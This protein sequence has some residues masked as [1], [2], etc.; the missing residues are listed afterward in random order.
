MKLYRRAEFLK[1]PSG[2]LYCTGPEFAFGCIEVKADSLGVDWVSLHLN[3]IEANDSGE[4]FAR[5]E[6]MLEAGASYPLNESF[7]RDGMF[8]D[9]VVFLVFEAPDLISLRSYIDDALAAAR[10]A[11]AP[12]TERTT[13]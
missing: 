10:P 12:E 1:L 11:D 2:T 7:G 8:D 4:C 9:D 13:P 5:L 6:E 3:N